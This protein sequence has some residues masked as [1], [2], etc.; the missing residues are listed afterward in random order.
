MD[1]VEFEPKEDGVSLVM[2]KHLTGKEGSIE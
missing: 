2:V 1:E